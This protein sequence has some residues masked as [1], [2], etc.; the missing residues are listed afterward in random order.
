MCRP[1]M[2]GPAACIDAP[3]DSLRALRAI[4][5]RALPGQPLTGC[6]LP[7]HGYL[8]RTIMGHD[9]L[10][11]M[12]PSKTRAPP[13]KPRHPQHRGRCR[14]PARSFLLIFIDFPGLVDCP[15]S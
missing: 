15:K 3:A 5:R 10:T 2:G 6:E 8:A 14:R 1:T 11:S 9:E 7:R 12:G 13:L 4:S